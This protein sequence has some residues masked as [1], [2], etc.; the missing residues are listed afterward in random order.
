MPP[1][2]PTPKNR[3]PKWAR[4][5]IWIAVGII[6]LKV[7]VTVTFQSLASKYGGNEALQAHLQIKSFQTTLGI[8]KA[9][10]VNYPSTLDGL[11]GL[12]KTQGRYL[13][14]IPAE[15]IEKQLKDPWGH[16]YQYFCPGKHHLDS[17][18]LFSFGPDGQ[19]NTADDITN[20]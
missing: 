16:P 15:E 3:F 11:A 13:P 18:D 12:F 7:I 14:K 1:P 19:P 10:G 17:Y 2:Q 5:L 6:I 8:R 9:G 20:W 4:I